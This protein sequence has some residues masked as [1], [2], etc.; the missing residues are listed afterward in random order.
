[1]ASTTGTKEKKSGFEKQMEHEYK[2]PVNHRMSNFAWVPKQ[3][4]TG[5]ATSRRFVRAIKV[6]CL[7]FEEYL[8]RVKSRNLTG[9][10]SDEDLMEIATAV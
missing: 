2:K 8:Q 1:M 4:R 3:S 7:R 5:M 6:E 10:V 9:A